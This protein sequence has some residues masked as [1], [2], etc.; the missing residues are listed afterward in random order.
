MISLADIKMHLRIEH[1]EEDN[2]LTELLSAAIHHAQLFLNKKIF[3]EEKDKPKY[4]DNEYYVFL[5]EDIKMALLI[6]I[7]N[8]YENRTDI[9]EKRTYYLPMS[10]IAILGQYRLQ[11]L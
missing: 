3:T 11:N 5:T 8:L 6:I 10:A 1:D 4:Q 9:S 7:C 2:Y